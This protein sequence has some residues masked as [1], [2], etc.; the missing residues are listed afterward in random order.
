MNERI[1]L[2]GNSGLFFHFTYQYGVHMVVFMRWC[3][4]NST[5]SVSVY[6]LYNNSNVLPSCFPLSYSYESFVPVPPKLVILQFF[7]HVTK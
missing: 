3:N 7:K 2:A 4:F 1:L 5:S 6:S